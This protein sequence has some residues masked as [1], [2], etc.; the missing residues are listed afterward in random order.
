[1]ETYYR[2]DTDPIV[3]SIL[4]KMKCMRMESFDVM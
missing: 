2:K 3:V 1:M 4:D